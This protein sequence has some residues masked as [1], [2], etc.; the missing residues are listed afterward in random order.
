[1]PRV[2]ERV[3][4]DV[5]SDIGCPWC[6]LGKHHL[7]EALRRSGIAAQVEL[8][9]FELNPRAGATRSA[10]AYLLERFGSG[11]AIDAAHA[12]LRSM[13]ERAGIRYD[14]DRA[15]VA[16][17]FDA[18]RIHHLAKT[19]ERGAEAM[20]RLM[21]AYH[22]EG[23]DLADHDVLRALAAEIG[24]DAGEVDETLASDAFAREV[25]EDEAAAREVGVQGVPF[26]VFDG[27]YA[28]SGAQP[29]DVLVE[30]LRMSA[31]EN[32]R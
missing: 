31:R 14:F 15:L 32:G 7:E 19:R 16:N 9:S 24:L 30:A 17:T 26:F 10:R 22:G 13:G 5:W 4:I 28:V 8:R 12:R 23:A 20:E 6:W 25:R 18:H 21:R 11:E 2:P 27:R 29:V 3:R 1:M